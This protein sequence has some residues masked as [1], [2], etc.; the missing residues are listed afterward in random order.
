VVLEA[1][2]S[3]KPVLASRVGGLQALIRDGE[4]GL[5]IDP[6]GEDAAGDLASR[7]HRLSDDAGLRK[8]LGE[9][10]LKEARSQY[11]WAQIGRKLE[12]LYQRAE[13]HCAQRS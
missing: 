10:G 7:L 3:G 13:E 2:S 6:N 8:R 5:F 1:W 12:E 11:D 4:T 9:A